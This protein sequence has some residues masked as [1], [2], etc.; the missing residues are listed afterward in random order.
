MSGI[1]VV[2]PALPLPFG[3]AD[4]RWLSAVLH[5]F[6]RRGFETTCVSCTGE[7]IEAV[8]KA[9]ELVGASGASLRHAPLELRESVLRRKANSLVRPHS[10]LARCSGLLDILA[11]ERAH[12]WDV[13]HFEHLFSTWAG[14][15]LPRAVTYVHHLEVV[16]WEERGD[17]SAR[18]RLERVQLGRATRRLLRP[19]QAFIAASDR[20]AIEVER[21]GAQRPPVVPVALDLT[22]YPLQQFVDA[23][24][25]GVIGSMHWHPSRAAAERVLRLWP[26]IRSRVPSASLV[27]AGWNSERYLDQY[28]PLDGAELLGAVDDPEDFFGQ[29][30]VL[31]YP[32]PRGS[33]MKI[34]VME[35]LAYGVPVLSNAEGLEGLTAQN[36]VHVVAA[37]DDEALVD[38]ASELLVD[39]ERRRALRTAGRALMEHDYSPGRAVDRLLSAYRTLGFAI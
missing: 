27:V 15:G 16:D 35:A 12:G 36:G 22:R 28:F 39:V 29:V 3:G 20:L 7:P 26:Q 18:E 33:G 8:R 24:V 34:K 4:A 31:A 37:E 38:Q 21:L 32:P 5:E 11:D 25:L 2:T 6:G 1:V 13:L 19:D 23:P 9:A 17:L 30:A 14:L 10:E